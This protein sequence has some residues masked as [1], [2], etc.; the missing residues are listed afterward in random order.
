[1]CDRTVTLLNTWIMRKAKHNFLQN[2]LSYYQ[3]KSSEIPE[4][5]RC[6]HFI[7]NQWDNG[8]ILVNQLLFIDGNFRD[9]ICIE[10]PSNE[11][12]EFS[13]ESIDRLRE[14]WCQL[15]R[16]FINGNRPV[17]LGYETIRMEALF[18]L[19]SDILNKYRRFQRFGYVFTYGEYGLYDQLFWRCEIFDESIYSC[20]K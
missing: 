1:M 7:P 4:Y 10:I 2:S 9:S 15:E 8:M 5:V 14:T 12:V 20:N 17:L 11:L 13:L 3:V 18:G 16:Y 6:K 19:T